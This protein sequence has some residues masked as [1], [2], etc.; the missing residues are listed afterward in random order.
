MST[1]EGFLFEMSEGTQGSAQD[2]W[3]YKHVCMCF[4]KKTGGRR[5]MTDIAHMLIAFRSS[6]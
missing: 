6:L 1:D 5:E 3:M 2:P 4:C